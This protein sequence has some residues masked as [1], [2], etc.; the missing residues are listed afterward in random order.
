[1]TLDYFKTNIHALNK[2]QMELVHENQELK[3]DNKTLT[4]GLVVMIAIGIIYSINTLKK[5]ENNEN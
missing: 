3:N 1:M 5:L 2:G 4:I